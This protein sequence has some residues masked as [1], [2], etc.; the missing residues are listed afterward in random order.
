MPAKIRAYTCAACNLPIHAADAG[1]L[2]VLPCP[3]PGERRIV[4]ARHRYTGGP[5]VSQYVGL[6][7]LA[8]AALT[9][10]GPSA[11]VSPGRLSRALSA[12]EQAPDAV[13]LGA[14]VVRRR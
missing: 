14:V 12:L 7:V 3:C 5:S 13:A 2:R 11:V 8:I 6:G 4:V 9:A 1:R 10:R